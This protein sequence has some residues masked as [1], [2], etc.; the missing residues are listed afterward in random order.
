MSSTR[1]QIETWI[2]P[3]TREL[4]R[5]GTSLYFGIGW[6]GERLLQRSD[7]GV[8]EPSN[9]SELG[10]NIG[11]SALD[12]DAFWTTG[13]LQLNVHTLTRSRPFLILRAIDSRGAGLPWVEASLVPLDEDHHA[14]ALR[15]VSARLAEEGERHRLEQ[16]WLARGDEESWPDPDDPDQVAEF[17]GPERAKAFERPG[18][19]RR[20]YEQGAWYDTRAKA[21]S[22]AYGYLVLPSRSLRP[23]RDYVLYLWSRSRDDLEP[24]RRLV[25]RA[26][27]GVTDL[28]AVELPSF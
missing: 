22:D 14:N 7:D 2:D 8:L 6:R 26:E 25:F 18:L 11:L 17:L 12:F 16:S 23:G 20:L 3:S 19:L 1:W 24:D 4:W 10:F 27:S 21:T 28:G 15:A 9:E 5:S 13:R